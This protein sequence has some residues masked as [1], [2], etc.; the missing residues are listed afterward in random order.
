M[1]SHTRSIGAQELRDQ[2][3][4]LAPRSQIKYGVSRQLSGIIGTGDTT[5]PLR[6]AG[7][8][9]PTSGGILEYIVTSFKFYS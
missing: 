4:W 6:D 8:H 1:S 2:L 5:D 7:V 3:I 9:L